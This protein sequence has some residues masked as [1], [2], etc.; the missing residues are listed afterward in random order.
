M[1]EAGIKPILT[2]MVLLAM[3]EYIHT[4]KP[5][6]NR[7]TLWWVGPFDGE[8][9]VKEE[10]FLD[11]RFYA[12]NCLPLEAMWP[13][14]QQWLHDALTACHRATY[15]PVRLRVTYTEGQV[16]NTEPFRGFRDPL[17]IFAPTTDR[18]SD[19]D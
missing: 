5:G 19:F 2:S 15:T 12:I 10:H 7:R 11:P 6:R 16:Q 17:L 8:P 13:V 9:T 3:M 14:E 1:E 4:D 18:E